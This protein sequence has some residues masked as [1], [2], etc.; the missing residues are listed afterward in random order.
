MET[1]QVTATGPEVVVET[2]E[3]F[4]G[5]KPTEVKAEVETPETETLTEETSQEEVVEGEEA[6][7]E[8]VKLWAGKHKT[9]EELEKY[10]LEREKS[11]ESSSRE[12]VRLAK[13]N[14]R[15][16]NQLAE[17]TD[18]LAMAELQSKLGTFAEKSKE[19][20]EGL[21]ES[22]R[23]TYEL[24]RRDHIAQKK[25]LEALQ[26]KADAE[27]DA[28]NSQMEQHERE[29]FSDQ[30]RFPNASAMKEDMKDIMN[31]EPR[32]NNSG[33]PLMP[34]LLY[35]AAVG[36]KANEEAAKAETTKKESVEQAKKV[37]LAK[38]SGSGAPAATGG[39]VNG[40]GGKKTWEDSFKEDLQRGTPAS[41]F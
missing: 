32:L 40:L 11:Y 17:L 23:M 19:E 34:K 24:D 14:E 13:V 36:M 16:A 28:I 7:V 37:S 31:M 21:T 12:S 38:S 26:A 9:P 8:P 33:I 3:S 4:F 20:L 5:V 27:I 15:Y 35:F 10:H 2:P 6:K 39:K 22:Q 25:E 41:I 30:K 29:L 1:N 18:K